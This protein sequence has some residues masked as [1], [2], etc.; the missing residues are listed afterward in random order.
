M[1]E[2]TAVALVKQFNKVYPVGHAVY[3]IKD[4]GEVVETTIKWPTGLSVN[5]PVIGLSC[6][7]GN[8]LLD[9]VIPLPSKEADDER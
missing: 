4:L 9:R 2:E 7:G 3:L 5:G 6:C 8:W 1:T